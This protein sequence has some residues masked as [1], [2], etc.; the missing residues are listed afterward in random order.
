MLNDTLTLIV[1]KYSMLYKFQLHQV[2][3]EIKANLKL[4]G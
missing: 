3:S 4:N 1:Y 2:I